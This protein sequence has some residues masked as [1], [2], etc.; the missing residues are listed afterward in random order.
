ME[1]TSLPQDVQVIEQQINVLRE[2]TDS[3]LY[4]VNND[5][6]VTQVIKSASILHSDQYLS[7][8]SEQKKELVKATNEQI[9]SMVEEYPDEKE[10]IERVTLFAAKTLKISDSD[11]HV[12]PLSKDDPT[13]RDIVFFVHKEGKKEQI[14][15]IVKTYKSIEENFLKE[16]DGITLHQTLDLKYSKAVKVLDVAST[17]LKETSLF[18]T[19]FSVAPGEKIS[20]F[21]SHHTEEAISALKR[22]GEGLG[23]LHIKEVSYLS[24]EEFLKIMEANY[25]KTLVNLEFYFN[26]GKDEKLKVAYKMVEERKDGLKQYIEKVKS[27]LPENIPMGYVHGDAHFGN[28]LYEVSTDTFSMIDLGGITKGLP[29][30]D[31]YNIL[32]HIDALKVDDNKKVLFKEAFIEGYI[33][34][35]GNLPSQ[36]LLDGFSLNNHLDTLGTHKWIDYYPGDV[37]KMVKAIIHRNAQNLFNNLNLG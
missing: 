12:T 2:N 36:E 21:T 22:L 18:M 33:N 26:E 32:E 6:S 11:P 27:N 10:F 28:F 13:T 16:V 31:Y 24:K 4:Y 30:K 34:G 5:S 8:N 37:Q 7:S 20:D 9:L 29:T 17:K 3:L 19:A 1:I 35:G 25:Q 15:L 14:K 23:E